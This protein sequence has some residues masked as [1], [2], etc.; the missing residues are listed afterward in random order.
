MATTSLILWYK[1][2]VIFDFY[3]CV[4]SIYMTSHNAMLYWSLRN[5][6]THTWKY[7][8]INT[9]T[10]YNNIVHINNCL[11][12]KIRYHSTLLWLLYLSSISTMPSEL[13]LQA[14][15]EELEEEL[16][17]ERA[18][19]AKVS[20]LYMCTFASSK[21]NYVRPNKK[22]MSGS[23]IAI[24]T[25]DILIKIFRADIWYSTVADHWLI[26]VW[27]R[28]ANILRIEMKKKWEVK[29]WVFV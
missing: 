16:E 20:H 24:R 6:W 14:R 27:S 4:D 2:H 8:S 10:I 18:A 5:I 13:I 26:N 12:T 21:S 1:I 15:I 3:S 19:R 28:T 17:A 23:A 25:K 7:A 22:G 29:N 9:K 11:G